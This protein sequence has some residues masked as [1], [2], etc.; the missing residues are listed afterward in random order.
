MVGFRG[1]YHAILG[2]QCYTKFIA[3]PNYT[4]FKLKMSGPNDIIITV[5]TSHQHCLALVETK[6]LATDLEWLSKEVPVPKCHIGSFESA[7]E[8]NLVPIDLNE[9]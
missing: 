9:P 6:V 7:E 2:Q 4:Y 3:V 8:T 1:T 5:G